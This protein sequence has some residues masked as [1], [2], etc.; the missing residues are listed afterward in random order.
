MLVVHLVVGIHVAYVAVD[1]QVHV[2]KLFN[3]TNVVVSHVASRV[4]ILQIWTDLYHRY[5]NQ[6]KTGV[7]ST[8][9]SQI[10]E[11]GAIYTFGILKLNKFEPGLIQVDN[12]NEKHL[13]L[14]AMR[15]NFLRSRGL[16]AATKRMKIVLSQELEKMRK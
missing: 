4:S 5:Y 10:K 9:T 1:D 7:K 14:M 3:S 13:V 8:L 6:S 11:L 16:G 12:D 2:T 15:I